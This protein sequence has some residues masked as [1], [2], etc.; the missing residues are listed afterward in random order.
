MGARE[1]GGEEQRARGVTRRE[2]NQRNTTQRHEASTASFPSLLPP[3]HDHPRR[4][5][6]QQ[7]ATTRSKHAKP[8]IPPG[9][10]TAHAQPPSTPGHRPLRRVLGDQHARVRARDTPAAA[11]QNQPPSQPQ[12]PRADARAPRRDMPQYPRRRRTQRSAARTVRTDRRRGVA[13]RGYVH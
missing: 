5:N 12:T 6:A 9:T 8:P 7:N 10:P 4:T 2:P 1:R 3:T 13:W 11:P